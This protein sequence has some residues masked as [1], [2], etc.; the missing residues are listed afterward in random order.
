[1]YLAKFDIHEIAAVNLP[2]IYFLKNAMETFKPVD[3]NRN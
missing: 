1:M 2:E 3:L